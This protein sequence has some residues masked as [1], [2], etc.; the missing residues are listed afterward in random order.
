MKVN[1]RIKTI[2]EIMNYEAFDGCCFSTEE[3]CRKYEK[4]AFGVA[5]ENALRLGN[6]SVAEYEVFEY[7]GSD[8]TTARVFDI[9]NADALQIVNTYLRSIENHPSRLIDPQYIGHKVAVLFGECEDWYCIM[10]TQEE[11]LATITNN[12]NKL[13]SANEEV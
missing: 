3:E 6:K 8:C 2:E 11:M 12:I 5:K 1:T 13:F 9:K 4:S 10:G 7:T